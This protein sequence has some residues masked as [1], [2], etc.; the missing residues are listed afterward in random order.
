MDLTTLGLNR[1]LYKDTQAITADSSLTALNNSNG[2]SDGSSGSTGTSSDSQARYIAPGT[3]IQTSPSNNRVEMNPD[4]SLK[5]YN[6]SVAVVTIDKNGIS[7]Q[8]PGFISNADIQTLNV[9]STFTYDGIPQPIMYVGQV[10]AAGAFFGPNPGLAGWTVTHVSTGNY[11]ITHNLGLASPWLYVVATP[12]IPPAVSTV[13][14]L[15]GNFFVVS[16]VDDTG[17]NVDAAFTF[18]AA[19]LP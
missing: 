6:N 7:V 16:I 19:H 5:A 10:T 17:T 18:H 13:L 2:S 3:I 8:G 12:W 4:D 15:N 9:T 1:F 14:Q 11:R